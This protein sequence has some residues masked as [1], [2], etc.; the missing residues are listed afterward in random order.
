MTER[1]NTV[2]VLGTLSSVMHV[3]TQYF[4]SLAIQRSSPHTALQSL[5]ILL[6]QF[7]ENFQSAGVKLLPVPQRSHKMHLPSCSTAPG[8]LAPGW[9]GEPGLLCNQEEK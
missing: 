1:S 5:G 7:H 3:L 6:E 8:S 2:L 4:L 9:L